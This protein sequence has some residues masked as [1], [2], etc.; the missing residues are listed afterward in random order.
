MEA[1]KLVQGKKN[2]K[3]NPFCK[4]GAGKIKAFDE[5]LTKKSTNEDKGI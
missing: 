3:K 2:S 4:K 1:P 5:A